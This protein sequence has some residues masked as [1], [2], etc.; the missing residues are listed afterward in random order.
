M[1]NVQHNKMTFKIHKRDY[2]NKI[3]PR[4]HPPSPHVGS[5]HFTSYFLDHFL[6]VFAYRSQISTGHSILLYQCILY[7]IIFILIFYACSE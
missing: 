4:P 1:W 7:T 2:K 6:H 3:P 5:Y